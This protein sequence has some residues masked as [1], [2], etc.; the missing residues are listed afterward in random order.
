MPNFNLI[1]R[2]AEILD[3]IPKKHF[4]L[5]NIIRT[6]NEDAW[7]SRPLKATP[8][9]V[10][11]G[12]VGCAMGWLG[13]HPEFNALGLQ[14]APYTARRGEV[15]WHGHATK[16]ALAAMDIF[17]LTYDEASALFDSKEDSIYD[18]LDAGGQSSKKVFK[19]R[20]RQFLY[21]HNQPINPKY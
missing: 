21:D 1:R 11:C 19:N 12:A 9:F 7:S 16:Y 15:L 13:M 2:A 18:D 8:A 20:I 3:G 6:A 4:D 17:S 14:V 5:N 10:E